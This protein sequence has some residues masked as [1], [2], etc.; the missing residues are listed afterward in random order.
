MNL[1]ITFNIPHFER[2]LIHMANMLAVN[3][4]KIHNNVSK[5]AMP[6]KSNMYEDSGMNLQ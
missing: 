3:V 4:K 5:Q 1:N 6:A 2:S